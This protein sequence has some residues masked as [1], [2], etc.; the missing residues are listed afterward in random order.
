MPIR[1]RTRQTALGLSV[2]N[3]VGEQGSPS[4]KLRLRARTV[5]RA[6]ARIDQEWAS[7]GDLQKGSRSGKMSQTYVGIDVSKDK[8]DVAV[9]S[10]GELFQVTNDDDGHVELLKRL[11]DV[12]PALVVLEASGGYEAVAAGVLWNGGLSVAVVNPRQVRDFAKGMGKLAKTDAIDA[13]VLALFGEKVPIEVRAPLDDQAR[14]LQAMV[15]RRRQLIEMLT[16]EKNRR[17]LIS[18]GRARKSLD[19]HIGWLEEAIRRAGSD[20]DQAVRQSP[21][22]RETEDLFRSV[23]GIGGVTARTLLAELPELGKLNR[24]KIAALVGVA[25]FNRD[26]GVFK[27]KRTIQGGRAHI[28]TVLYMAA[29]TAARCNPVIRPLYQRLI[30]RGKEKK[31][32]LVAC[33]RKLLTI[34]TAMMRDRAR[35]VPTTIH[36]NSTAIGHA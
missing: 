8:L 10:E 20:I 26:S 17:A 22:W 15:L 28:R 32:A 12:K 25:P 16:M 34:L 2:E 7:A 35:F 23:K 6:R 29:L 31:V 27:G 21:M 1:R 9:G 3:T 13:R 5:E 4:S 30:A 14:E 33:I 24:K 11:R 36:R 18:T 19:K